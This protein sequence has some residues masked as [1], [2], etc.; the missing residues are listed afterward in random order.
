MYVS[1]IATYHMG[2]IMRRSLVKTNLTCG[3]WLCDIRKM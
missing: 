2:L 3:L 1:R